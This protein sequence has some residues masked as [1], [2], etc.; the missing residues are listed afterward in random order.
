M[1]PV[2]GTL[3]MLEKLEFMIA[4]ARE[5]HFGR[6]A[7]SCGV[8][9]PTL[10]LGIQSLEQ[11][12]NVQLVKRSSRFQ[13]FTPE[14]ERV[15]VWAR[16]LVGDAKAMRQEMLNFHAGG[17]AQLRIAAIP[18][19]MQIAAKL[20]VP[21]QE[22]HPGVRLR[23]LGRPSN[24][25]LDLLNQREIDAGIT[26]ISNEPIGD[27][28]SVPLY[29][30][31]FMLL[32]TEDGPLGYADQ[33]SWEE[34]GGVPLCLFERDL[35]NRRIID[36]VLRG[37]GVEPRPVM[38]TDSV[39][40]LTSYVRLGQA[41]SVVPSSVMEMIDLGAHMRTIPI[42]EPDIHHTIG[43]VVSGRFPVQPALSALVDE[44][45]MLAPPDLLPA[46]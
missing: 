12:L 5:R 4:L 11:M 44:A 8:A 14:G 46:V 31:R 38:E 37:I 25:L 1:D 16:R 24:I 9:Q 29:R 3:P 17:G 43:L 6:A 40:A 20:A 21:F 15:L 10:S 23:I 28:S 41:A 18:C 27:V 34:V 22:R 42:V 2:E 45:H 13:G 19:S 35:Q 30:D 32:T 7:E 26:Y 33:A 39:M 36:S